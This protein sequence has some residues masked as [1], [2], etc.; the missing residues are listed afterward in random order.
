MKNLESYQQRYIVVDFQNTVWKSWMVNSGGDEL[1]TSSGYPAG[2]VFRFF[3]TA[4]KWKRD[5]FG[6]LVFCYEGGEK[7]RYELFPSYKAGRNKDRDFDP[8]P[9]IRSLVSF[10]RC[11]E[12]KPKHAEADDA[13]AAWIHRH[14]NAQHLILSSDK[15]LWSCRA[16]NVS[17]VSFQ[18]LL[19]DDDIRKSCTKH[20]GSPS[21]KSITMAKALFGDKSDGLPGVPRLMKKH[22]VAL[23]E[24]ADTPDH[25]FSNLG[26]VPQKTAEKLREHEDQIRTMYEVVKLR[27]D[28]RLQKREREGDAKGLRS[29]LRK[30]ECNSLLPH[31]DFMTS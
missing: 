23:I 13:I 9:D 27:T 31:V 8:A 15:D 11:V 19:T 14:P 30:F 20:Y 4:Y 12:I 21:P 28:V 26:G 22:V 25:L 17:I 24:R 6:E 5:F 10:L 7:R 3:R 16:P 18:D 2:H 1:K 29:F